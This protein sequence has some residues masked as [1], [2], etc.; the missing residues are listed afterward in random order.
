MQKLSI[1]ADWDEVFAVFC[2]ESPLWYLR[3]LRGFKHCFA[4]LRRGSRIVIVNPMESRI[5]IIESDL[6]CNADEL[7]KALAPGSTVVRTKI[8]ESEGY[9]FGIFSCVEVVKKILGIKDWRIATPMQ[10]YRKLTEG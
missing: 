1:R 4:A 9:S 5:E 3:F 10:L 8:C 6:F 2:P 7:I